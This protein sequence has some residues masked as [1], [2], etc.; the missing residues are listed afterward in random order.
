MKAKIIVKGRVQGVGYRAYVAKIASKYGI[1]GYAMNM[2]DGTVEVYAEGDNANVMHFVES[3]KDASGM[4]RAE[5][6]EAEINEEGTAGYSEPSIQ[7]G[8]KFI[9]S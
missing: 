1:K 2:Q 5:V 7:Y 4:T 8:D 6:E 3:I 9:I